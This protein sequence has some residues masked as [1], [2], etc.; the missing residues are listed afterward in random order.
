MVFK[1]L[2]FHSFRK[3]YLQIEVSIY[4]WVHIFMRVLTCSQTKK[5]LDLTIS[6]HSVEGKQNDELVIFFSQLR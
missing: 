4:K 6:K 3:A 1:T 2:M 5:Q